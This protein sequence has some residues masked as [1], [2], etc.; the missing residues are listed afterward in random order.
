M[1]FSTLL[2]LT[3]VAGAR[4]YARGENAEITQRQLVEAIRFLN[5]EEVTY[6]S[7]NNRFGSSDELMKWLQ[8]TEGIKAA[9]T[10]LSGDNLKPFELEISTSSD[11]NHYQVEIQRPPETSDKTT[12][13]KPAAFSDDRG[14][15]FLGLAL[16]C[17]PQNKPS[18]D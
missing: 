17:E 7:K 14:V 2:L 11:G 5:T 3:L 1:K 16:G 12:W 4:S 6:R 8:E 9:P 13:C 18:K 10:I 15:I